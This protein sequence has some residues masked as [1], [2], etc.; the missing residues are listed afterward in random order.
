MDTTWLLGKKLMQALLLLE[1]EQKAIATPD[2]LKSVGITTIYTL[3]GHNDPMCTKAA[4][5]L[6]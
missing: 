4:T 6:S 2:S 3:M 5:Q 1:E